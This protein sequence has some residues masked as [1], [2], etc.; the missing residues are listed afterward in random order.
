MKKLLA[1]L[2]L[3]FVMLAGCKSKTNYDFES[4]T[5]AVVSGADGYGKVSFEQDYSLLKEVMGDDLNKLALY[6]EFSESVKYNYLDTG[7]F[8]NGDEIKVKVSYDEKLA[9]ELGLKI[10]NDEFVYTVSGLQELSVLKMSDVAEITVSGISPNASIKIKPLRSDLGIRVICNETNLKNGQTVFLDVSYD[11]DN[12]TSKGYL[13]EYGDNSYTVSGLDEFIYDASLMSDEAKT[14]F[15]DEAMSAAED[16]FEDLTVPEADK[17]YMNVTYNKGGK[18]LFETFL[19]YHLYNGYDQA[20]ILGYNLKPS[21]QWLYSKN[22]KYAYYTPNYAVYYAF[23]LTIDVDFI[24]TTGGLKFDKMPYTGELSGVIVYRIEEPLINAD[25]SFS[26]KGFSYVGTYRKV[27][28]FVYN[29]LNDDKDKYVIT[30]L[31]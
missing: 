13:F 16:K 10:S 1:I 29:K 26:H 9:K 23:D 18:V 31:G 4:L 22:G 17:A 27:D 25:G 6:S 8:K 5:D 2:M 14:W 12:L 11:K 20:Y 3:A 24:P 15:A 28:E 21:K 19:G 30:E 7:N